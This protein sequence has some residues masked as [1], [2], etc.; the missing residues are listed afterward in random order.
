LRLYDAPSPTNPADDKLHQDP[1]SPTHRSG[2]LVV[3]GIDILIGSVIVAAVVF[4][5]IG[6]AVYE[7]AAGGITF[8][9]TWT[10]SSAN[11]APVTGTRAGNGDVT[12]Q[13]PITVA[14]L[15]SVAIE[16][17]V[18]GGGPRPTA[19]SVNGRVT[20]LNASEVTA[21]GQLAPGATASQTTLTFN[22]PVQSAPNM[23]TASGASENATLAQLD[24]AYGN[25][26]GTGTWTLV[27]S[28]SGGTSGPLGT[29][30][31]S[32]TVTARGTAKSFQASLA[33][34]VPEINR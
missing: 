32:Y 24:D 1:I 14:N 20:P 17:N 12:L 18:Q 30:A 19:V 2:G 23:T 9:V 5:G 34:H 7:P 10:E 8:D 26:L 28:M 31:E 3:R 27:I 6:I 29:G 25:R 16:V 15:T 21:T 22:V 33:V 11:L 4:S 13:L